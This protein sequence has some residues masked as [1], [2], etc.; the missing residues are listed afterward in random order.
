MECGVGSVK[1]VYIYIYI[2]IECVDCKVGSV[3][4]KV[5]CGEWGVC[6]VKFKVFSGECTV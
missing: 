3:E 4:C 2:Y 5:W 1:R 6:S